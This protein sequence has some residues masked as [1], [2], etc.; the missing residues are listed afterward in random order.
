MG[1]DMYLS[2]KRYLWSRE[3]EAVAVTG[4]EI[5]AGFE[6]KELV[7][8]AGY[9]RKANQIHKW[10]VDHVQGGEDECNPY[11]VSRDQLVELLG[12]CQ[13]V[14]D[15]PDLIP[16]LLPPC[17]GFFFGSQE[18]DAG[19]WEDIDHTIAMLSKLLAME[20]QGWEFEYRSSW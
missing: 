14:K 20:L 2:A 13:S 3:R 12:A 17:E 7:C 8:R 15:D 9:W 5:P 19:Y 10:F 11:H 18:I 6:L 4:V 16:K 1:L